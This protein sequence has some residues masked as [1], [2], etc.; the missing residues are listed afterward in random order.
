MAAN[1]RLRGGALAPAA[2]AGDAHAGSPRPLAFVWAD[3]R[4]EVVPA[5]FPGIEGR[6]VT[7]FAR[8]GSLEAS[9]AQRVAGAVEAGAI[10]L[11]VV[12][13][14][15]LEER[16]GTESPAPHGAA[17][18]R[19]FAAIESLLALAPALRAAVLAR[20][21]R[22]VAGIATQT[23]EILWLGEHSRQ[24]ALLGEPPLGAR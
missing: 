12:L 16:G 4:P 10:P 24:R 14:A 5:L 1:R 20:R 21:T 3:R 23:G 2:H 8:N 17:E 7:D 18:S 19:A 11:L 15:G 13:A 9:E 6:V 22:V